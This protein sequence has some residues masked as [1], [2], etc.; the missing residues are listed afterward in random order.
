MSTY[1]QMEGVAS[2]LGKELDAHVLSHMWVCGA[3]TIC[4]S[5]RNATRQSPSVSALPALIL[6]RNTVLPRMTP[7]VAA[8][9]RIA[10]IPE[11]VLSSTISLTGKYTYV[12]KCA[13]HHKTHYCFASYK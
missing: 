12:N 5:A 10:S 2:S 7:S 11:R 13:F 8:N 3:S 9:L 4:V 6:Q 1:V